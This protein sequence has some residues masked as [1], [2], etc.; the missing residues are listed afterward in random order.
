MQKIQNIM[1]YL[2]GTRNVDKPLTEFS[3]VTEDFVKDHFVKDLIKKSASKTCNLDAIPTKLLKKCQ[4][5]LI[6]IIACMINL[7]LENSIFPD[8]WNA[9]LS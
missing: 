1:D 9:T 8:A 5:A 2:D 3:P 6:P 7:S 4:N